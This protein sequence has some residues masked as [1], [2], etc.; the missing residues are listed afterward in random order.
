MD[1]S[2]VI[3]T[4]EK[5]GTL[6]IDASK[7]IGTEAELI[8]ALEALAEQ[9]GGKLVVEKHNPGVHHHHHGKGETHGHGHG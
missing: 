3:V 2:K 1:I 4:I 9:V 7:M 8:D 6:K 5:D